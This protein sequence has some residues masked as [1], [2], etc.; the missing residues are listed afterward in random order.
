M[1]KKMVTR[2]IGSILILIVV[3]GAFICLL[4]SCAEQSK[5]KD[6]FTL[7]ATN[8]NA[9]NF[10]V[11]MFDGSKVSLSDLKGKVVLVNFW[12][13]WCP[14]C[15]VELKRVQSDLIDKFKDRDFVFL[16]ISRGET[17]EEIAKFREKTGYT[18]P[19]GMDADQSIYKSYAINYIPRNYLIG[20]DGKIVMT[21]VGY[22]DEEFNQLIEK[23]ELITK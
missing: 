20:K 7:V 15:R 10:T 9:P 14:P 22:E 11:D 12:A 8:D 16:P 5:E 21:S 2:S 4:P 13:T 3:L 19:M 23:I 18:F 6:E 17:A 1:A